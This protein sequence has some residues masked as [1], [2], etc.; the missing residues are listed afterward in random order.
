MS[1]GYFLDAF[2]G[3]HFGKVFLD[4]FGGDGIMLWTAGSSSERKGD[5][6]D[7]QWG[8][9]VVYLPLP[10]SALYTNCSDVKFMVGQQHT[11]HPP[12]PKSP[13]EGE[14]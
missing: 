13:M 4:F 5:T 11:Q 14:E 2:P 9:N 6:Q 8:S 1:P 12:N 3:V 7:V 10:L